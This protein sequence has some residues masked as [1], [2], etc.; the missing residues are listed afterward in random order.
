MPCAP[1]SATSASTCSAAPTVRASRSTTR[2]FPERARAIVLDSIVPPELALVPRI[3]IESQ[4][5][6]DGVF[7][8]CQ[9]DP[10]CNER[11]PDLAGQ[12]AV[13]DGRLRRA[14]RP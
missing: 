11:F 8:R 6:L 2:R 10:G 12:F 3:A 1:R 5:V 4:A 7:A 14:P 9:A 13:L